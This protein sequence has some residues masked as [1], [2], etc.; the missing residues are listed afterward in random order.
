MK[1]A[2]RS[3][4]LSTGVHSARVALLAGRASVKYNPESIT[5]EIIAQEINS[6]GFQAEYIAEASSGRGS[7]LEFTVYSRV[8]CCAAR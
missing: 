5:P 3:N 7:I 8:R 1:L 4:N 6:L 2:M